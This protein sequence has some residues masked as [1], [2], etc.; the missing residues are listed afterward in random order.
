M[1]SA[2]LGLVLGLMSQGQG[3]AAETS[4]A[5]LAGDGAA[6]QSVRADA[7][8]TPVRVRA[9]PH[10]GF[11]RIV[12]DWPEPVEYSASMDAGRLVVRFAR[13]L[14]L[15]LGRIHGTLAPYVATATIS[16]D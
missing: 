3:F 12:F 7:G 2:A 14:A 15:S 8:V 9:W 10:S 6:E 1:I 5:V 4:V 11:D 16:A 13:P